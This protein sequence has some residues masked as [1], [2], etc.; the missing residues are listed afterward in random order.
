L[1]RKVHGISKR[2][3]E[4]C[5]NTLSQILV[6]AGIGAVIFILWEIS[7]LFIDYT[8]DGLFFTRDFKARCLKNAR[9]RFFKENFS[10][11]GLIKVM[12]IYLI[13]IVITAIVYLISIFNIW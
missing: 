6:I 2:R 11:Q 8:E 4:K 3:E 13:S 7:D 12:K 10:K 1:K 5:M 9:S